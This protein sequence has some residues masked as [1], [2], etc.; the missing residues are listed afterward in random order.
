M[1]GVKRLLLISIYIT[2]HIEVIKKNAIM[3]HIAA[4]GLDW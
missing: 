1:M 4:M 3:Q 2:R